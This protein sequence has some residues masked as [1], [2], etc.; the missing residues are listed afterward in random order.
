MD[1]YKEW[2]KSRAIWASL[3]GAVVSL[4]GIA[5][6]AWN[7][8]TGKLADALTTLA[9]FVVLLATSLVAWW[10]RVQARH[11]IGTPL[12]DRPA[13]AVARPEEVTW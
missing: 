7:V 13:G 11:K 5:G 6:Y 8:D 4:L 9:P 12:S 2:W 10:G 3:I 1:D